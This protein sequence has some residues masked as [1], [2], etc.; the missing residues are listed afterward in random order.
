MVITADG[1]LDLREQELF[2]HITAFLDVPAA[3]VVNL[4]QHTDIDPTSVAARLSQSS[5]PDFQAALRD[6]LEVAAASDGRLE[7]A[8]RTVLR[9]L[10]EALGFEYDEASVLARATSFKKDDTAVG[11]AVQS[12]KKAATDAGQRVAGT[13]KKLGNWAAGLVKKKPAEAIPEAA[14]ADPFE[15]LEKLGRLR[16]AGVLTE[17]EFAAK[18]AEVLKRL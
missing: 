8:E 17:E 18:K 10:E 15:L 7:D 11:K 4:E 5:D 6:L 12:A 9:Q 13:G 16:D 1:H 14:G 2:R 3:T